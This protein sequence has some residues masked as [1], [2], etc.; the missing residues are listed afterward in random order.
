MIGGE[1]SFS[2]FGP[3][4]GGVFYEPEKTYVFGMAQHLVFKL[5]RKKKEKKRGGR[6]PGSTIITKGK[7]NF[8]R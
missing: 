7:M 8:H 3:R 2:L 5:R 1:K 4:Q 6:S